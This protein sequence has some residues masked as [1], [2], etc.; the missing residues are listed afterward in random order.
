METTTAKTTKVK[1]RIVE[2][3]GGSD[4]SSGSG[5]SSGDGSGG[6]GEERGMYVYSGWVYHLGTNPIGRQ[7]CHLRFLFIK[8]KFVKMYKRD[9]QDHPGIKHIRK[10]VIGPTL[11]VEELGRRKINNGDIYVLRFYNRLDETKKGEVSYS[12]HL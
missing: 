2:R 9:P 3:G 4:G 5:G 11:M 1:V 10:G 12:F 7:Y 8:G 6:G